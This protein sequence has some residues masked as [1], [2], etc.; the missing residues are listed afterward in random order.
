M[1][2]GIL[3]SVELFVGITAACI[4]TY[5]PLFRRL[6]RRD[7]ETINSDRAGASAGPYGSRQGSRI[8]GKGRSEFIPLAGEINKTV[9]L[10]VQRTEAEDDEERLT[11]T[12]AWVEAPM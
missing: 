3:S 11:T 7:A 9:D 8:P 10:S 12:S 5:Q 1:T 4:P 6:L 2:A